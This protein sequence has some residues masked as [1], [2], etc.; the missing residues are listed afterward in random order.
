MWARLRAPAAAASPA[1]A[2]PRGAPGAASPAQGGGTTRI[3]TRLALT[4]P[5]VLAVSVV[6][7]FV[8]IF[9]NCASLKLQDVEE[10]RTAG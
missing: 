3:A 2:A 9:G 8:G 4:F 10:V 7:A 6:A 5:V 1:P